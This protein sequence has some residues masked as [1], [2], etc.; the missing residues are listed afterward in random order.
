MTHVLTT[1]GQVLVLVALKPDSRVRDIAAQVDVTDRTVLLVLS[2]LVEAGLITVRRR[3]RRNHY[4]VSPKGEVVIGQHAV[5][6][7]DIVALFEKSSRPT[8]PS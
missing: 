6:L 8:S 3:G 1:M 7:A 4:L 5:A 2:Q